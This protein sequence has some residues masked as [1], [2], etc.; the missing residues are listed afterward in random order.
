LN[1]FKNSKKESDKYIFESFFCM[2]FSLTTRK[3]CPYERKQNNNGEVN[4]SYQD[5]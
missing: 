4:E 5:Y 1:G 3:Q 2:V